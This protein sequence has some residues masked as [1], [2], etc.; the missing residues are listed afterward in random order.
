MSFCSNCGKELLAGAK[1]CFECGTPVGKT[2]ESIR[3]TIFSGELHKCPS[4]GEILQS[5]TAICPACGYE[6][7]SA[8]L[9]SAMKVFVNKI[10]ECDKIIANTS[11]KELPKKGWKTW[12]KSIRVLWVILNIYTSC[13]PL[14]IYFTLPLF[15]PLIRSKAT[16]ELSS[17][18]QRK[19]SLIENFTFP[20][21]RESVL[22]ALFFTKSKM[23]FLASEKV[24]AKNAFWL[25]LWNT[26][27]MQLHQKANIL[28]SNDTI[29]ETA[30]SDIVARKKSVDKKIRIRA[31][32]GAAI[33]IAF[34]AFVMVNG[35]LYKGIANLKPN[36]RSSLDIYSNASFEWLDTGLCTKIPKIE[37]TKGKYMTNSDTR[38]DVSIEGFTYTQFEKYI[39][40]CKKAGYTVEASKDTDKYIAYNTEGYYLEL[41]YWSYRE[42]VD[43]ELKAP[44]IGEEDFKWPNHDFA[45]MIPKITEKSGKTEIV[46]DEKLKIWLYDV[47]ESELAMYMAECE[48]SGFTIDAEKKANSFSAFNSDGY[49]LTVSLGDMKQLSITVDAPMELTNI[50]WPSSGPATLIPKPSFSVGKIS[51]DYSWTFSVFLSEMT[52]EDFN[53]YVDKCIDTGFKKD[54]RSEHYFSAN[55]GTD[56]KLSVEYVGFNTIEIHIYDYKEF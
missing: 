34:V 33:I 20:N 31:G 11:K 19:V 24:N 10:N 12:K 48:N 14:V 2:D 22:E 25:Q 13:I 5:M 17:T 54:Y 45:S 32:I 23:E 42:K 39:T 30:Y 15:R 40:E 43:I 8:K 4:C 29:A 52:I 38:L 6:I 37:A 28:L 35:S 7:N 18:E 16:P 26:K 3:R 47:T 51:S 50:V 9:A 55:K 53:D 44:L 21:D 41:H 1:Y 49:K 36:N 46:D 56:I 27:A